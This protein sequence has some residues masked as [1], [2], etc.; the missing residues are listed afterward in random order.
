M[1]LGKT[2]MSNTLAC[3]PLTSTSSLS[4]LPTGGVQ[5]AGVDPGPALPSAPR[6]S[7]RPPGTCG[8]GARV[9]QLLAQ[10]PHLRT[11]DA[12]LRLLQ[13]QTHTKKTDTADI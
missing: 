3:A 4:S 9:P 6:P 2:H 5:P 13:V 10:R 1:S 11:A 8:P 7:H 12:Q